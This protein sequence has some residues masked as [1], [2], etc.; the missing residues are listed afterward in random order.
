MSARL[1]KQRRAALFKGPSRSP[2]QPLHL[3]V[4]NLNLSDEKVA[5]IVPSSSFNPIQQAGR[6]TSTF[7]VD[8]MSPISDS[9]SA[10]VEECAPLPLSEAV[11][12]VSEG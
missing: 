6:N 10:R 2:V 9:V 7:I 11:K 3:V 8:E 1:G 5:R 12:S 4:R